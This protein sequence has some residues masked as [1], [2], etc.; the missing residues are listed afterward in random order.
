VVKN[1]GVNTDIGPVAP[2]ATVKGSFNLPMGQYLS[3]EAW[4]IRVN[5]RSMS[6]G[7]LP[8][9]KGDHTITMTNSGMTIK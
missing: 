4:Q 5:S 2:G 1:S 7:S 3:Y 6:G 8:G 9:R